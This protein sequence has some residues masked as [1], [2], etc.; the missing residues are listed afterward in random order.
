M[1]ESYAGLNL[2]A[3]SPDICLICRSIRLARLERTQIL[4]PVE[5]STSTR[6]HWR[7]EPSEV[8]YQ[9]IG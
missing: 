5:C 6:M 8:I 3:S 9:V 1:Q 7:R 2:T 4:F